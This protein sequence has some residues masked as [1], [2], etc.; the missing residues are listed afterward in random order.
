VLRGVCRDQGL[1]TFSY[2]TRTGALLRLDGQAAG[3]FD[4]EHSEVTCPVRSGAQLALEVEVRSLPTHGL[5]SGPGLRWWLMNLWAAQRPHRSV[6]VMRAQQ[7]AP[8]DT[9]QTAWPLIGHSH[10]DVAWLWTYAEARRKA[11]RTFAIAANLLQRHPGF[12]FSQSQPQLYEFVRDADPVFFEELCGLVRAQRFDASIAALWV[13]SDCNVPSGESLLRQMLFAQDFCAQHF[14]Q[15]PAVA[16]LPDSFGFANTLPTLLAHAGIRYFATTKLQW[17]DTTRFPYAQFRWRGPDGSEIVAAVLDSYDGAVTAGRLS[18]AKVR[19]EPVVAGFGDGGGGVTE[20]IIR[21]AQGVGRWTRPLDWFVSLRADVL[22][23]H[24]DELYLEYH[25]GVYTTHHDI[26]ARNARLERLLEGA[27]EAVAWCIAMR[28]PPESIARWRTLLDRAWKVVLRNQFHDVL[29]GTS[30]GA[31]YADARAEYD[32]AADL[33]QTIVAETSSALPH[34]RDVPNGLRQAPRASEDRLFEFRNALLKAR[35]RPNGVIEEL[36][37]HAG[38]NTTLQANLLALYRDRPRAWDAWNID[39]GYKT[40]LRWPHAGAPRI[41]A[42]AMVVPFAFGR[43]RFEMCLSLCEGEPFLRVDV[44][45]DWHERH[46]LLRTESRFAIRADRVIY[47]A[48]HGVIARTALPRTPQE[49]AKFEVPGQ[50]FALARSAGASVAILALDTYGWNA[51]L[52]GDSLQIGHSLLRSPSWPQ[53]DA[54]AG[55]QQIS[56]AFAPLEDSAIGSLE[57]HWRHF[58]RSTPHALFESED[59]AVAIVACKPAQDGDGVI[60]RIRECNGQAQ[61]VRICCRVPMRTAE[62]ADALERRIDAPVSLA[63]GAFVARLPRFGLRTFR[64]RF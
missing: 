5:P 63:Q 61:Q 53:P 51:R 35:V 16:W 38:A 45:G 64:V 2:P 3:A 7:P 31:V 54:D 58:A 26:K 37:T 40:S 44:H 25:R 14:S 62:A 24:A 43:S 57:A 56:Y 19:C 27:E 59:S 36:R 48:P 42:D 10:L 30:I 18:R 4:R 11:L 52:V 49:Q 34:E 29:P 33:L 21:N 47:G 12:V 41:Q 60:V 17:N 32:R 39:A 55:P 20:A 22:P 50:R 15:T 9:S 6:H 13:E 1:C 28:F 46:T 23:V 8:C